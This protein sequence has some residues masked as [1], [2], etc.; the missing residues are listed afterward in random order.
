MKSGKVR[1]AKRKE[2]R[3]ER[4]KHLASCKGWYAVVQKDLSHIFMDAYNTRLP[5]KIRASGAP[6][7]PFILWCRKKGQEVV[8]QEQGNP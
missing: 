5:R 1:K 2:R 6:G 8:D 3:E 4:R 7:L